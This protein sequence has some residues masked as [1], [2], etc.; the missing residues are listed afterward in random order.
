MNVNISI[1]TNQDNNISTV[2]SAICLHLCLLLV[3]EEEGVSGVFVA[4][5]QLTDG[6][7]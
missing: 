6:Q 5:A 2:S 7:V 1:K 3:S 4:C